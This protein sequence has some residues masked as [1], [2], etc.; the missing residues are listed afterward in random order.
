MPR[1]KPPAYVK[2]VFLLCIAK[3]MCKLSYYFLIINKLCNVKKCNLNSWQKT[4]TG[5]TTY[6]VYV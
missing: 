4:G 1:G 5:V 3:I 2:G 6:Y